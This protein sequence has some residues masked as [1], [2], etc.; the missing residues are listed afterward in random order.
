MKLKD[1]IILEGVVGS[2]AYGLATSESDIDLKGIF[3]YP[4]TEIL[5]LHKPIE[6]IN[7]TDPDIEYHE[8]EKFIRLAASCN[9]TI[10]ELLYLPEYRILTE[11][12]KLLIENRKIFLSKLVY[13]TYGGYALAQAKKL[14]HKGMDFTRYEKHARHC[15]RLLFQAEQLLTEQT[16]DVKVKNPEELFRIG[17]QEPTELL[18]QFE[19][20]FKKLDSIPTTLPNKPDYYEIDRLLLKIR[21]MNYE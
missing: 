1:K 10:L 20:Q 8:V 7:Q 5:K 19:I 16:L 6:T 14:Y 13:K 15:F 12:G 11:E 9:P 2:H 3:V 17:K 18:E 21:E 4:V